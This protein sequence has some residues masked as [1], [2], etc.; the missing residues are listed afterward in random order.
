YG[1]IWQQLG[2]FPA[3][4]KFTVTAYAK[5][6]SSSPLTGPGM[7]FDINYSDGTATDYVGGSFPTLSTGGWTQGTVTVQGQAG[8]PISSIVLRL[9][10]NDN[11]SQTVL[12]DNVSLTTGGGGS[13]P[14]PS[15]GGTVNGL[16]Q[17]ID[18]N[19][20]NNQRILRY[21]T[22]CALPSGTSTR[23]VYNGST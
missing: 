14:P 6:V 9:K 10:S 19:P 21:L 2:S 1:G 13:A 7:A 20:S 23:I 17:W 22:E 16:K 15:S 5:S 3:G 12:F 4:T 18:S 8:H 11:P